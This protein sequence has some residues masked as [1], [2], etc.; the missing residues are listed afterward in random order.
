[1]VNIH[2]GLLPSFKGAAPYAQ[3][4]RAGVKL[5]GATAHFV[6]EQLD[7]G[8]I[9]EQQVRVVSHRDDYRALRLKSQTLEAAALA[10]A[11]Q[12]VATNRVARVGG[13]VVV[14]A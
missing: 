9:I 2:H 14:F 6:T 5:I 1:V 10:D 12:Y 4:H 8:P 13:R 3:A 11:V 7:E